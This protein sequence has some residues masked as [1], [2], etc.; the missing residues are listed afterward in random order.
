MKGRKYGLLIF[1][2]D[3]TLVDSERLTCRVISEMLA[4]LSIQRSAEQCH[5][6]FVGGSMAQ[7]CT[8][9]QDRVS[10]HLDEVSFEA[11]YRARTKILFEAELCPIDGVINILDHL[12]IKRCV[13]SNGPNVKMDIT[14]STTGL[15]RFFDPKSIYSAYDIGK[16]KPDPGLFLYAAHAEGESAHS[17]LVIEDTITGVRGA[18]A[19]GMDV[20][21]YNPF[22][23]A[24]LLAS[25][26]PNFEHMA[27]IYDF[28]FAEGLLRK[29]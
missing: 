4:E 11:D 9:V 26:A 1:D 20:L 2:C 3:G 13:A 7:V 15:E 5:D 12:D 14:L 21:A 17:C 29:A 6:L 10:K 23:N 22:G 18:Q 27:D 16:W 24:N 8:Y 25:G 19:A 28:L